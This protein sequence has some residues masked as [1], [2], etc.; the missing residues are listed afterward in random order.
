MPR[1]RLR[2]TSVEPG[3]YLQWDEFDLNTYAAQ[4]PTANVSK[5]SCDHIIGVWRGFTEKLGLEFRCASTHQIGSFRL[6]SVFY[7]WIPRLA[8]S[9]SE[10][11]LELLDQKRLR[12]ILL[13][14]KPASDNWMMALEEAGSV[15]IKRGGD[16]G[17][18]ISLI[19]YLDL[20]KEAEAETRMGVRLWI[21]M[22]VVVGRK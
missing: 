5:Q 8:E 13:T 10:H 18:Q 22:L 16:A 20:L 9:F 7:S 6:N 2:N 12:P 3:G 15:I 17:S 21:D 4:S 14:C 11:D 1:L 19:E